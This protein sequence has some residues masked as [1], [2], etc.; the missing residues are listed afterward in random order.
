MG[1]LGKTAVQ[2]TRNSRSSRNIAQ[3]C[4]KVLSKPLKI[5]SHHR[6]NMEYTFLD[7]ICWA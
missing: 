3:L 1:D 2:L 7:V 5:S 6:G 4:E